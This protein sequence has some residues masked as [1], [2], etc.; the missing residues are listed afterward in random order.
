MV[1]SGLIEFATAHAILLLD[2]RYVLQLRDDNP[3][4]SAP[5]QWSLFGGRIDEG[6]DPLTAVKRELMEE[7]NLRPEKF[8]ELWP[9][10][11]YDPFD[12]Q[13]IRTWFFWADVTDVWP[14]KILGEGQ[15]VEAFSLEQLGQL[16]MPSIMRVAI[17]KFDRERT[18]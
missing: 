2:G 7:L 3:A 4:I 18:L 15:G 6:E 14:N 1:H 13:E 11:Y 9:L 5:G 10:D 17:E 8:S 16:D 12:K